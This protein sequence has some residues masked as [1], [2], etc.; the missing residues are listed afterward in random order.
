[1][2][3]YKYFF[4]SD[5]R[6]IPYLETIF[7][8]DKNI[9]VVTTPP[10]QKG[11]GKKFILNAVEEYCIN[12]EIKYFYYK[13][14][15]KYDDMLFG[16]SAS[17]SKIFT[18]NFLKNNNKIYNIH[19][20][21]L[22]KLRGPSPVEFSILNNFSTTG[23]T[24]FEVN[25]SIDTGKIVYQEQIY[26]ESNDYASD[27]YDKL[28]R[29]F[30]KSYNSIDFNSDGQKQTGTGSL[31]RKFSKPDFNIAN[32][33]LHNS[34][35]KIRAFNVL[36]PAYTTYKDKILKIHSYSNV[37]DSEGIMFEEGVLYPEYVTP[38]G[39]NKMLFPDYIRGIK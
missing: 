12:K 31:T 16:I 33:N 37:E 35:I 36:G 10:I 25:E 18:P 38:E 13:S 34:K 3:K 7:N 32:D 8:S 39:K 5:S 14:N 26:V 11:R 1:V 22:P 30:I 19:L 20:S 4:G 9:K 6:S 29:V 21:L 23:I 15:D 17:F 2:T 28:S 24:V 27:L